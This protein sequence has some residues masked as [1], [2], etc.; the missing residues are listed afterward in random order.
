M[1]AVLGTSVPIARVSRKLVE[2][3]KAGWSGLNF[4]TVGYRDPGKAIG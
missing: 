4:G 2:Q 1:D 3:S